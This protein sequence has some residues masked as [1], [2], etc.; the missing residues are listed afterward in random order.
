M[1]AFVLNRKYALELPTSYVDMDNEEMEYVDGGGIVAIIAKY[2]IQ[3]A[4]KKLGAYAVV[5]TV[6]VVTI[7]SAYAKASEFIGGLMVKSYNNMTP[8]EKMS[9]NVYMS[10]YNSH[11]YCCQGMAFGKH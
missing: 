8:A 11:R 10:E 2:A 6:K 1:S 9:Y 5:N 4:M 3:Y 7:G